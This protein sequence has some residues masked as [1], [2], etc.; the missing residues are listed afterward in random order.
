MLNIAEHF[1]CTGYS[2][3]ST[4]ENWELAFRNKNDWFDLL[5]FCVNNNRIF[6]YGSMVVKK[7]NLCKSLEFSS[8]IYI[9]VI[10]IQLHFQNILSFFEL[11][12]EN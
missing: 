10:Y 12:I 4:V 2:G 7:T 11:I 6:L 5:K 8:N 9:S 3:I 1:T